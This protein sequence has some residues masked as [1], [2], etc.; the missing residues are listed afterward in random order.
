MSKTYGILFDDI[1]TEIDM[2]L[3]GEV[4]FD[5]KDGKTKIAVK[6]LLKY[7]EAM[8]FVDDVVT[9]CVDIKACSYRPEVFDYAVKMNT[10][11]Y[12]AGFASPASTENAYS[13]IYG[14]NLYEVVRGE[15]D[16]EQYMALVSAAKERINNG[17]EII[18]RLPASKKDTGSE[19]EEE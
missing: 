10:L 15:I 17:K 5:G 8:S 12:Y 9:Q 18:N 19:G 7:K 14:T 3:K 6:R 2:E 4:T 1:S 11:V 13:V 16:E